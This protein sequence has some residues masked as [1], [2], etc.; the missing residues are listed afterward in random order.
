M[1]EDI[2]KKLNNLDKIQAAR[3]MAEQQEAARSHQVEI[4]TPNSETEKILTE[5]TGVEA[6]DTSSEEERLVPESAIIRNEIDSIRME[7]NLS[8]K[9]NAANV[10]QKVL[11]GEMDMNDVQKYDPSDVLDAMLQETQSNNS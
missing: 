1:S 8:V 9:N 10:V 11:N 7:S 3:E 4:I 6:L 5:R 2:N